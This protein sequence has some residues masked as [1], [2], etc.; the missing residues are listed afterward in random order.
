MAVNPEDVVVGACF[1]TLGTR[2]QVRKVIEITA[3]DHVK[4]MSRGAS[5]QKG[6]ASWNYGTAKSALP[7]RADFAS[8][9]DRRV[10]CDWDKDYPERAPKK[11][12]A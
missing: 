2:P 4:Y 8:A 5:Y 11:T 3:D 1:V 10:T 7:L 9:V 6:E 12:V